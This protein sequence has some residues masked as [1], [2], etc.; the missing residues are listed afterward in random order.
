MVSLNPRYLFQT[1]YDLSPA[2]LKVYKKYSNSPIQKITICRTPLDK[3]LGI[4]L[5]VITLGQWQRA[6]ANSGYDS[7]MHL[8]MVI[9]LTNGVKILF[10]KNESVRL[11]LLNPKGDITSKTETMD[12]R[13]YGAN[14]LTLQQL[15]ENGLA[16]MGNDVFYTYKFD[17]LNCQHFINSILG[18]NN[19]LTEELNTFI[20]QDLQ[21][22]VNETPSYLRPLGN[23]ITTFA[24]KAREFFGMG[25]NL[26]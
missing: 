13:G 12:V 18:A 5:N 17:S 14:S 10:E 8:F 19:L 11:R 23:G 4:A 2:D 3:K 21:S 9:T 22:I 6:V 24:R 1:R 25:L 16:S 26:H 15:Y 7:L 20:M